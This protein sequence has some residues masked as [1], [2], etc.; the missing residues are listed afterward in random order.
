MQ[1]AY[2]LVTGTSISSLFIAGVFPGLLI[3][4]CIMIYVQIYCRTRG[5]DRRK[6]EDSYAALKQRGFVRVFLDGFWALLSPVIIL[7]GIY[8]GIVTPAE[9][10]CVSVFYALIVCLFIYR[11]VKFKEL[12]GFF[13]QAVASF[14]PLGLMT[15]LAQAFAKILVLLKAPDALAAFLSHTVDTRVSFLL[16]LNCVLIIIGMVMDVAP[17]MMIL[18]PMLMPFA[19]MLGID[20][21]H[22]G[23]LMVCNLAIGFVTP[24]FGLNLFISAPMVEVGPMAVG[25]RALPFIIS[26]LIA[27]MLITFI[28]QISLVLL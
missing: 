22:L 4:L 13:C 6:V 3:A 7:G 27:L 12:I 24:P 17:A 8:S 28:P 26:F 14:A 9:A 23:V 19:V 1:I 18:S 16:L 10:A 21:V 15:G 5:E 11:T 25:K 20:P 2:G